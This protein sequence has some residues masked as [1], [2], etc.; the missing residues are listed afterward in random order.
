LIFDA[1][2]KWVAKITKVYFLA[3]IWLNFDEFT[4]S[5]LTGQIKWHY[6]VHKT[7]LNS[8]FLFS[9]ILDAQNSQISGEH[10]H[11]NTTTDDYFLDSTIFDQ[12]P[13]NTNIYIYIDPKINRM[14]YKDDSHPSFS[15]KK[16]KKKRKRKKK[17]LV[18]LGKLFLK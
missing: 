13:F 6:L 11:A 8:C 10:K 9:E 12:P 15:L 16:K 18:E 4:T 17:L 5:A 3:K 7:T 14:V 1:F 2:K